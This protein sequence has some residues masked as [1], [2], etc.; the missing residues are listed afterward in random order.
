[1]IDAR[2]CLE[3]WGTEYNKIKEIC[4]LAEK[5]G[6]YGFYYGESLADIDLDCWTIISNL[7]AITRTIKLGPVITYLFPQYRNISLLAKQA[8]T[9]Q[10]I[11]NKRLEFRT[12]TGATLQW[13]SQWWHPYGI[14][15]P[16]ND[17]R[18][19]LLEEGIQL[20]LML[21][22]K[23]SST[24]E[25]NHFKVKDARLMKHTLLQL[26]QYNNNTTPITVAAKKDN[27]MRIAAKY[28][29]V[30]ECS[31]LTPEQFIILNEKF[32]SLR[33]KINQNEN[34][35]IYKSIELDV[36]ISESESDLEYKKKLFAMERGPAVTSQM[37]KRGLVGTPKRIRERLKQYTDAGV[38]QFLLAFQDPLDTKALELFMTACT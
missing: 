38:D 13:A 26:H 10:E 4:L 20:L 21:W 2:L 33:K 5:L 3:I 11:S 17:E 24:F 1:M 22:S 8:L 27:T 14:D 15:Y 30:W 34:R 31:Y 29:N 36:I 12:G 19:A 16:S 23:P 28:A 25:G 9:L 18:V 35:K 6:Y 7:S 37:I 32:E